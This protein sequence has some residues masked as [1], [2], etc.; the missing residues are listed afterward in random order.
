MKRLLLAGI[1][2]LVPFEAFA[3][4]DGVVADGKLAT[5]TGH[6]VSIGVGS[7]TYT[8]PG[9]QG[10]SIH[11]TKI[12]GDYRGTLLLNKAQHWFVQAN[13]RGTIGNVSYDGW[14][15]PFL[16]TPNS[17][18]PN[19]FELTVGDA[20]ACSEAGDKDWYVEARALVGRDLIG[21][22]WGLSP[23]TGLGLRHLSNGTNGVDG[24]RIDDYLYLPLAL[25]TRTGVASHGVLSFTLEYD[26]L[27]HGWQTTRDSESGGGDVPA[28][29]MAPAFTIAGFSDVSFSQSAGWAIRASA[30]YQVT[31][32]LAAEPYYL[33]WSVSASPVNSETATFTVHGLTAQELLGFY[34]PF[35]ITNEFGMRLGFHF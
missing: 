11:G 9:A 30:K 25:T 15:S 16:I 21:E 22:K 27:I 32:H 23:A 2:A 19:G 26:R 12:E 8:E 3:Q 6:E 24:Y 7:Y 5:P 14:C 34:E 31:R 17:S 18:S 4:A 28:M 33:R 35:N 1:V 13:V 20:S 29:P 10:I